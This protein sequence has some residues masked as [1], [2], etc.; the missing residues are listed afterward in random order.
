[1]PFIH[2]SLVKYHFSNKYT[3]RVHATAQVSSGSMIVIQLFTILDFHLG[4]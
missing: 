2:F 4:T 3:F 1:M